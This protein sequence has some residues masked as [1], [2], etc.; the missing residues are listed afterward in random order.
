[1]VEIIFIV[2]IFSPK[3]NS[4]ISPDL[5]SVDGFA[6]FSFTLTNPKS[7]IPFAIVLLLIIL[8]VF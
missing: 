6:F 8:D 2:I 1:M 4:T 3:V 7:V 5:T